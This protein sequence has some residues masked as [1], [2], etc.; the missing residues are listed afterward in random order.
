MAVPAFIQTKTQASDAAAATSHVITA[1]SPTA[2]QG[3]LV[4]PSAWILMASYDGNFT[5]DQISGV[6]DSDG[7]TWQRGNS[8]HNNAGVNGEIWYCFNSTGATTKTVTVASAS[9]KMKLAL[10]EQD[11]VAPISPLDGTS[12]PLDKT[13]GR[14]HVPPGN[15][16]AR[17]S[18][19]VVG[20]GAYTTKRTGM[21]EVIIGGI[22][23]NDTRTITSA[24]NG[25]QFSSV[26]Q[27]SGGSS[28][29]GVG[30]ERKSAEIAN[31]TPAGTVA[32]FVMSA[33]D[34]Q[35]AAVMSLTFFRDG[36]VTSTNED[37]YIDD[38]EGVS[39]AFVTAVGNTGYV[40]RSS[41][42]APGGGTGGSEYS[43]AFAQMPRYYPKTGATV[44][45]PSL[46]YRLSDGFH[47]GTGYFGFYISFFTNGSVVSTT[48]TAD[49][50][51]PPDRGYATFQN[52]IPPA[53]A[54]SVVE[55]S[56][57][58]N[59][60]DYNPTGDWALKVTSEGDGL[61]AGTSNYLNF[62][63]YMTNIPM[64]VIFTLNYPG[65]GLR[66]LASTG[67]GT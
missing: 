33:S 36:V 22:A 16:T 32:N 3:G 45:S 40:Y 37:G 63:E 18:A 42:S 60:L 26:V 59:I 7:D 34:T 46:R 52:I 50:T 4:G 30:L 25:F 19:D 17:T 5:T 65:S 44:S 14:I 62:W 67:V 27:V 6:T 64:Y 41:A 8:A 21:I 57:A 61:G 9:V 55:L 51:V 24:G 23:W 15:G 29:L 12:T 28:N 39:T 54:S 20:G 1:T 56:F 38:I 47:D 10:V 11:Q 43:Q 13:T 2:S 66:L 35:P 58:M 31:I 53:D 49:E 48:T